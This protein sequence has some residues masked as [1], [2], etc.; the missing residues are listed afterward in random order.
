MVKLTVMRFCGSYFIELQNNN[1]NIINQLIGDFKSSMIL[2][3]YT[4]T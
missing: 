2:I 1:N 4:L 3:V